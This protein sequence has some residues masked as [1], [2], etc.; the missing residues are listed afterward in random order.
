[1]APRDQHS[2]AI[3]SS[4]EL[5]RCC[6]CANPVVPYWLNR[7]FPVPDTMQVWPNQSSLFQWLSSTVV[8]V[9]I[10][11]LMFSSL[12]LCRV[13]R[14]ISTPVCITYI[15]VSLQL[16]F[17][18]LWCVLNIVSK[19]RRDEVSAVTGEASPRSIEYEQVAHIFRRSHDTTCA[20][21]D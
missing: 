6:Q 11:R 13:R 19:P 15:T 1:M 3:A 20:L 7:Y 2:H 16:S 5:K 10:I 18:P 14:G 12:G 17:E 21:H 4:L 8:S 9:V